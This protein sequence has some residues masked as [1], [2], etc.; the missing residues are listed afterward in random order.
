[1]LINYALDSNSV[2]VR[3]KIRQDTT[4]AAP[5]KGFTG[6]TNTSSG[7]IVST[8]ADSEAVPVSYTSAGSTIEAIPTLGQY[9]APAANNCRLQL[10]SDALNPGVVELQF[11]N[12]RFAVPGSKSLLIS[13][14][15]VAGMM[16]CDVSIPLLAV[17]PYNGEDFGLPVLAQL[18]GAF[19]SDS[20][21]FSVA[22][23]QNAPGGTGGPV[24][25]GGYIPGQDPA[26]LVFGQMVDGGF[27]FLQIQKMEAAVLLGRSSGL[28]EGQPVYLSVNGGIVRVSGNAVNGNRTLLV[29]N[30]N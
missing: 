12:A 10:V 20:S 5:G 22:A 23:L 25:V 28:P 15:G 24:T 13:I 14:T 6:L 16:D 11:A 2:I 8:I 7:L 4:G 26:S 9:T 27:D 17:D 21:V 18:D 29:L 30:P 19:V 1:V 3:V